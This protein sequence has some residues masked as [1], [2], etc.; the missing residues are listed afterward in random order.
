MVSDRRRFLV[1]DV[2]VRIVLNQKDATSSLRIMAQSVDKG[3]MLLILSALVRGV[4]P[5]LKFL[6]WPL[7]VE[8]ECV[9]AG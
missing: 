9:I 1:A 5:L 2:V 3:C 8:Y 7:V 4:S 6:I